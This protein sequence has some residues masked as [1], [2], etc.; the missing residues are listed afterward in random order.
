MTTAEF[1]GTNEG[2]VRYPNSAPSGTRRCARSYSSIKQI[3]R[4]YECQYKVLTSREPEGLQKK[5]DTIDA[6]CAEQADQESRL[7]GLEIRLAQS[8]REL[9]EAKA[10]L[11]VL[12]EQSKELEAIRE[13]C[14]KLKNE[15]ASAQAVVATQAEQHDLLR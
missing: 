3:N 14:E 1:R 2:E 4:R 9:S 15:L 13:E 10:N 12:H 11:S 5:N 6:C 8:Q 7:S